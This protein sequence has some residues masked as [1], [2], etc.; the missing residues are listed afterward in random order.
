MGD[1]WQDY[2]EYN[3]RDRQDHKTPGEIHTKSERL[4]NTFDSHV[5]PIDHGF[6]H[7]AIHPRRQTIFLTG[8]VEAAVAMRRATGGTV[9]AREDCQTWVRCGC[10]EDRLPGR[11]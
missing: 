11:R 5:Q 9:H 3:V 7:I 6:E 10:E 1:S 2:V 4:R 8:P